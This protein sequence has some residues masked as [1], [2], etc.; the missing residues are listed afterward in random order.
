MGDRNPSIMGLRFI[1]LY[2]CVAKTLDI[3]VLSLQ[4]DLLLFVMS[5]LQC[6]PRRRYK[7][8]TNAI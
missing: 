5:D 7:D 4:R 8:R 6:V 2:N 3:R 1:Y